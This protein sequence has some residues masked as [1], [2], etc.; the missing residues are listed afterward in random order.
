MALEPMGHHRREEET[1]EAEYISMRN[2]FL[3][4]R[5]LH[6]FP[7][8]YS[9][10]L[11]EKTGTAFIRRVAPLESNCCW[12]A[13]VVLWGGWPFFERFWSSLANRSPNMFTLIGLGT[14]AAFTR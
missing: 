2:R 8:L 12:A 10:M 7:F 1:P 11:G 4:Q 6:G 14:G 3:L 13:P 9:A 5:N